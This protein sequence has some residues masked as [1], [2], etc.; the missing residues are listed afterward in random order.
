MA[1]NRKDASSSWGARGEKITIAVRPGGHFRT[2]LCPRGSGPAVPSASPGRVPR[3]R[4][5]AVGY[6]VPGVPRPC[7]AT[8]R[9]PARA[10][11]AKTGKGPFPRAPLGTAKKARGRATGW[12]RERRDC[13]EARSRARRPRPPRR[14]PDRGVRARPREKKEPLPGGVPLTRG[15]RGPS[16]DDETRA[17]AGNWSHGRTSLRPAGRRP[18]TGEPG[19]ARRGSRPNR[20]AAA[21]ASATEKRKHAARAGSHHSGGARR[22]PLLIAGAATRVTCRASRRPEAPPT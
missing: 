13:S 1:D 2:L 12:G 11:R 15:N 5:G 20:D 6:V 7:P 9:Q 14:L 16:G 19:T 22:R 10:L 3:S 8:S 17:A 18:G 4:R 21:G